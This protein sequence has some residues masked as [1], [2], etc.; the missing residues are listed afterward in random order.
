MNFRAITQFTTKL[1]IFKNHFYYRK[2]VY[3]NLV[4]INYSLFGVITIPESN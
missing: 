4:M 3:C 1:W 2:Y